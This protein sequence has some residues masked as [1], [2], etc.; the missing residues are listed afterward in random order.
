MSFYKNRD[1]N[2]DIQSLF[3]QVDNKNLKPK[4]QHCHLKTKERL[5]TN[6]WHATKTT[7]NPTI[8]APRT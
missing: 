7:G 1:S 2:R 8:N 5:I 3:K 4:R 6:T